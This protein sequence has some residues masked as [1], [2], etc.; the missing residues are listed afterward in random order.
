GRDE[1][2]QRAAL[3]PRFRVEPLLLRQA[4]VMR[5]HGVFAEPLAQAARDALRH[6]PGVDE[7]QRRP[8]LR[9]EGSEPIEILLP[10]LVRHH[11]FERRPRNLEAEL[12][13]APMALVDDGAIDGS[14]FRW[15]T[16]AA[17]TS[18]RLTAGGGF[19]C[20]ASPAGDA[21]LRA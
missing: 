9:D 7:D 20:G 11:S 18:C 19:V 13:R 21:I 12:H 17:A 1:R 6:P 15:T 4:A 10:H 3:E 5:G 2:L 16:V 14:A 8:M